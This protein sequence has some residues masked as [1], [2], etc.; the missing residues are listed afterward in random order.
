V[1]TRQ[2]TFSTAP[3]EAEVVFIAVGTPV[4]AHGVTLL[5]SLDAV[6]ASLA[7][8][9]PMVVVIKSTVPVG[10]TA[11]VA[12]ALPQHHVAFNPEFLREGSALDDFRQPARVVIGTDSARAREVLLEL[13]RPLGA[14]TLTMDSRSAELAKYGANAMLAT[15]ISFMNELSHLASATGADLAHVQQALGSDPRIGPHHLSAGIGWG[16]SCLPKD[17]SALRALG[18]EHALPTALLDA[19]HDVNER[20]KRVLV[21]RAKSRFGSLEGKQFAV[22]GLSFKPQTDDLR[23]SPALELVEA[24]LAEGARV[25]VFDPVAMASA[26]AALA[27]RVTLGSDAYEV[28]AGADAVFVATEWDAF[29]Q[30]DPV[31]MRAVMTGSLVFDGRGCCPREAFARAGLTVIGV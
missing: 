18:R 4:D 2:L 1:A 31:R 10:T 25:R 6:V 19:V 8:L 7:A 17:L 5:G 24:L 23:G 21:E 26:R 12:H 29:R 13:H 16:G 27:S 11:R 20:Q 28:L 9:P 22:W 3:D 15:R 14:P 30:A